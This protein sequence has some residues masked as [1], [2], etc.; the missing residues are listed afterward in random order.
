MA[1]FIFNITATETLF[2]RFQSFIKITFKPFY[3]NVEIF[4]IKKF[5]IKLNYAII[6]MLIITISPFTINL[7]INLIGKKRNNI[8]KYEF[9]YCYSSF[10]SYIFFLSY[11]NTTRSILIN[12]PIYYMWNHYCPKKFSQT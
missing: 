11:T 4:G 12:M 7:K 9:F 10:T 5:L 6:S 1:F 2:I 3:D 8:F